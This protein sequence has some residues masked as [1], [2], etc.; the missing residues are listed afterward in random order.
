MTVLR[1]RR[2]ILGNLSFDDAEFI[3]DL[4]N[5]DSFLRYIGDKGV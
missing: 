2:L 5:D 3:V 4:L 1:T